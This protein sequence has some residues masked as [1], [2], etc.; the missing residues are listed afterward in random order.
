MADVAVFELPDLDTPRLLMRKVT[1][2]DVADL[3]EYASDPQVTRYT[4]W[5]HYSSMN[6]AHR[7]I[8]WALDRYQ[9]KS[10][11]PWGIVHKQDKKLIGTLGYSNWSVRNRCADISYALS[12]KYWG[13]GLTPEALERAIAYGF[14]KMSLNRIEAH[15]M[16]DNVASARV[17][18]KV[19]MKFEGTLRQR[20]LAKKKFHDLQMY[21]VLRGEAVVGG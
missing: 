8:Y 11:A 5:D 21:S 17:M 1:P 2:H 9:R 19:G 18:E 6:D 16:P 10:E 15:C 13:Q 4:S 7:F 20:L 3:L 14:E 12:A